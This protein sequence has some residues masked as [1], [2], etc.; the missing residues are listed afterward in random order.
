MLGKKDYQATVT[1]YT[2]CKVIGTKINLTFKA[3]DDNVH[4]WKLL[5]K[6][7]W[8]GHYAFEKHQPNSRD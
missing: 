5:S 2:L 3:L 8:H 7:L 6:K 4:R 1:V